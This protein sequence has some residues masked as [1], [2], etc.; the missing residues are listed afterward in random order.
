VNA[1]PGNKVLKLS[2][3]WIEPS[4]F[5]AGNW[6]GIGCPKGVQACLRPGL[7]QTPLEVTPELCPEGSVIFLR[8]LGHERSFERSLPELTLFRFR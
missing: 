4:R 2:A 3:L 5:V 1:T 6:N 7:A 8:P